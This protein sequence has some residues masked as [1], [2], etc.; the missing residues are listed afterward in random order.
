LTLEK[1]PTDIGVLLEDIAVSLQPEGDAR[2]I[3]IRVDAPD[4][5]PPAEVDAVRLREVMTN[6]IANALRYSPA[7]E[8]VSVDVSAA[9]GAVIIRVRDRGAGIAPEDL[10]HIFD[11]FHKGASSTGSGLGLTIAHNLVAAHGGTIR[12]ESRPGE[13]TTMVVV[14]PAGI[15]AL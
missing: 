14:V 13:G 2:G 4:G 3:S 15:I 5:L 8:V 11:R 7:G 1:E 6:L 12:A 9:G 10:P